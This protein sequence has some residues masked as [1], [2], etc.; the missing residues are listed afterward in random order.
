MPDYTGGRDWLAAVLIP[1]AMVFGAGLVVG[2]I[3]GGF[4]TWLVM[5]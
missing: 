5:R 1:A 2:A 3:G 4:V